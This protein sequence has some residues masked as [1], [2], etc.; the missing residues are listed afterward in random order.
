MT[1]SEQDGMP[2]HEQDEAL[3]DQII[4]RLN[5]LVSD[6]N[7][8]ADLGALIEMRVP[9]SETTCNHPTIQV[10][11]AGPGDKSGTFGFLGVLNGLVGA[12]PEG[13]VKAGW[14]YITA[15][16]SDDGKLEGFQKTKR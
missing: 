15:V 9:C 10:H 4:A 13:H 7:V 11:A 6:P 16:F 14:G 2:S 3:A 1:T 5:D 8:R 12:I